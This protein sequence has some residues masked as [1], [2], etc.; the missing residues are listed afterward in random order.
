MK[1]ILLAF[2]LISSPMVA[3]AACFGSGAFKSCYDDSGNSYTIQKF[4]NTT[5]MQGYNS[6][7][8]STWSQ[9]SSTFGNTTITNGRSADGDSWN[10]QQQRIGNST[11]YSGQD[12]D[13][14]SFSGTC[15][16]FG[17]N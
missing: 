4:G 15:G 14:N 10:M 7:T 17:C 2:A 1:S 8:G 12:S 13:G 9:D 11:F 3:E 5:A 16:A 6:R